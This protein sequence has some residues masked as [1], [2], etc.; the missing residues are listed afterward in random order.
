[1]DEL[2]PLSDLEGRFYEALYRAGEANPE[3]NRRV[4]G[5]YIPFFKGCQRVLD[6]GCGQGEFLELLHAAGIPSVG[7]D[8]DAEMI[9]VCQAKGLQVVRADLFEYLV[10]QER[11]F[12]GIFCSN[13]IEH[14]SADRV[15]RFL[16]L[17][18]RAL[19]PEGRILVATPNPE[20]LI[21]HLYEFWRDPTHVRLYN[22]PLLKFFM[23]YVGFQEVKGGENP[24][25][26]WKLSGPWDVEPFFRS[27]PIQRSE[28]SLPIPEV[29][30]GL[31]SP[32]PEQTGADT[33]SIPPAGVQV[34]K[35]RPSL[36]D[37]PDIIGNRNI[38][39]KL[40]YK[41]RRK[42]SRFLIQKII[43]EEFLILDWYL[44]ELH[45]MM[46]LILD[47]YLNELHA[48]MGLNKSREIYV[49]GIKKE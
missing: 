34:Q 39:Q 26:Q 8:V 42:I 25:T 16:Q 11:A 4:L 37:I 24:E 41:I 9:R 7:I 44:N 36:F 43:Y 30:Q 10:A 22:L 19:R 45:A 13:V 33:G 28:K 27:I 21:V 20:N 18:H 3:W 6:V 35:P 14:M 23:E 38:I 47:W 1:M 48:I 5:F 31:M 29:S 32:S 15:L 12:D 46:G 17:A 49:F 2:E 40:I